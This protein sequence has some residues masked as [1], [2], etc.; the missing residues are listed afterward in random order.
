EMNMRSR[1]PNRFADVWSAALTL[2][3]AQAWWRCLLVYVGFIACVLPLGFSSGF[4]KPGLAPVPPA[5]LALLPIYLLFRPALVEELL[6]RTVL[7]PRDTTRV[8]RKH[9]IVDSVVALTRLSSRILSTPGFPDQQPL[10][11]SRARYSLCARRC[12]ASCAP[13]RT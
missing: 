13:W 7:L 9:L 1:L 6:F 4:L 8:S 12:W 2:P 3:S 10:A 5:M 11:Y